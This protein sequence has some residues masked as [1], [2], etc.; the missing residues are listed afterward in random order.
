[1][2][3]LDASDLR[4]IVAEP[5]DLQPGQLAT[6]LSEASK[7]VKMTKAWRGGRSDMAWWLR[8][9]ADCARGIAERRAER[10]A[11]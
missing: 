5:G 1:M 6:V 11:A 10:E 9:S 4:R 8:K 2:P 7:K 3:A